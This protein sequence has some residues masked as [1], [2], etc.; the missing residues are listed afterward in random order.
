[1]QKPLASTVSQCGAILKACKDA[2][3][4]LGVGYRSHYEPCSKELKRLAKT[5]P[6]GPFKKMDGGFSFVLKGQQ[7]RIEKNLSGGGPLMDLG[8]YIIQ[9]QF[10]A[11][12][13]EM[14]VA[15]TAREL[16]KERPD[17]FKEV[18]ETIEW[19][20]EFASGTVATGN[21]SY[22][23]QRN[24]FRA[25]AKDGWYHISSAYGY[26]GQKAKS[27]LGPFE[28]VAPASVQALQMDAFA[29]HV[30]DGEP[31]VVPGEMGRRDL[32]VVEA[33]YESAAAGGKRVELKF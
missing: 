12:G 8:I 26:K 28:F 14:P 16:T 30:R 18:E 6:F 29:R 27:H 23:R 19:T 33:I 22:N 21:C 20:M 4:R 11:A 10:M 25:E 17:F 13:D 15:I 31:N 3:V 9:G 24:E 1:M 5:A 7:W 32:V 2:K